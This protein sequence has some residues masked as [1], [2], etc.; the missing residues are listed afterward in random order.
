MNIFCQNKAIKKKFTSLIK[1]YKAIVPVEVVTFL[2]KRSAMLLEGACIYVLGIIG[3]L[4][5]SLGGPEVWKI[6]QK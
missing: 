1:E 5:R 2:E 4:M 3:N 6:L